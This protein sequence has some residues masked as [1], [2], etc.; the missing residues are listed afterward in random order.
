MTT[1]MMLAI[2]IVQGLIDI[3][4]SAGGNVHFHS[5]VPLFVVEVTRS[6]YR[7]LESHPELPGAWKTERFSQHGPY[8]T[9]VY[10]LVIVS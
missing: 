2:N 9:V 10:R 7:P 5:E 1:I 4:N 8:L 3:G 6:I